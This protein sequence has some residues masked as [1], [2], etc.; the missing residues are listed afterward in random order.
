MEWQ[1]CDEGVAPCLVGEDAD[2]QAAGPAEGLEEI[3]GTA[4]DLDQ[5][6]TPRMLA[7]E[8]APGLAS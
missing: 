3:D 6:D 2:S 4:V 8:C 1:G 5:H 7:G